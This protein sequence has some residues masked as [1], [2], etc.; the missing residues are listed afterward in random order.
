MDSLVYFNGFPGENQLS[1]NITIYP[2]TA[3]DQL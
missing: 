3:L 2:R 1:T